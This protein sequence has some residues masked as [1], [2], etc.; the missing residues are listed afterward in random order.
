[1]TTDLERFDACMNYE[2]RD[3]RPNHELGLWGQT[4]AR[5]QE[6]A[7]EAV[8]N[9]TWNWFDGEE[10]LGFDRREYIAV[11][12]AFLPQYEREVFEETDEYLVARNGKGI[13][14]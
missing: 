6:E 2:A 8:E 9:F 7:P 12:F 10:G 11:N 14:V 13:S 5:W 3:R 4:K 1:M